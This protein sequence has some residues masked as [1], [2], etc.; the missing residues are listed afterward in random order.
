M[1]AR[2]DYPKLDFAH[3]GPHHQ[4][5]TSQ[6]A[7]AALDEIDRL[8]ANNRTLHSDLDVANQRGD[9][10]RRKFSADTDR[11]IALHGQLID[12]GLE[13][14]PVNSATP[15][16]KRRRKSV[17]GPG[18][19]RIIDHFVESLAVMFPTMWGVAHVGSSLNSLDY[20]DIDLR[21]V[22]KDEHYDQIADAMT[23]A[24]LNMLLSQWGRRS[25]GFPIDCQIQKLSE[26]RSLAFGERGAPR[27]NW[28]GSGTLGIQARAR[29][30]Q[31]AQEEEGESDG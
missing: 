26:H 10:W 1:S 12:L 16:A 22:L 23:V 3:S 11:I 19:M 6:E 17:L 7:Q 8:R 14:T 9:E 21:I 15:P 13:A 30:E 2:D 5:Q 29:R 27:H 20:R 31:A 18:E 24:D 28:R 25:T 4:G